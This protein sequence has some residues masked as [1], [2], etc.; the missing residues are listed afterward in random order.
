MPEEVGEDVVIAEGVCVPVGLL[1]KEALAV[2]DAEAPVERE[3]V[4]DTVIV[5]LK[6]TVV[7][8]VNEA[9]PVPVPV[10]VPVG[11]GVGV[12]V[13]VRL[14]VV[15]AL[16]DSEGLAPVDREGVEEGDIVVVVVRV[17]V[18]EKGRCSCA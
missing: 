5:E 12:D 13:G 11:V 2:S 3:D 10:G 14:G 8:G 17:V 6:L 9:V 15:E 18:G 1:E 4:G 16:P 7:E